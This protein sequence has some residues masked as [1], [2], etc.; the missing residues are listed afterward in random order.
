MTCECQYFFLALVE[1]RREEFISR[2]SPSSCPGNRGDLVFLS[3]VTL[4]C[5]QSFQGGGGEHCVRSQRCTAS[6]EAGHTDT[7]VASTGLEQPAVE[8]EGVLG[9]CLLSAVRKEC[10]YGK[11]LGFMLVG[12]AVVA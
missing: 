1:S 2:I 7:C 6:V 4:S 3:V 9:V 8:Q 10:A 11:V 5:T 12:L